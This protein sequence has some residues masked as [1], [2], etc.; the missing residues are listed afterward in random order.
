MVNIHLSDLPFSGGNIIFSLLTPE[1]NLRPGYN[2]FYN[3]PALQKMAHAT[4]VRI[5]LS[6]QSN[7]RAAGVNQRHRYYAINEITISGRCECH[8]HADHCETSG[9][10]YPLSVSA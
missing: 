8:G 7:S 6:G 3:T 9:K 2:D 1:P 4:Q 5:H 10:P